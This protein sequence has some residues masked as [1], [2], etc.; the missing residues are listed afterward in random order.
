M[1]RLS[2]HSW[3]EKLS[4]LSP[5]FNM[6]EKTNLE[7]QYRFLGRSGLKVSVLSLGGN[8]WSLLG[9]GWVTMGSQIENDVAHET[10]KVAYDAG[11]NFFDNGKIPLLIMNSTHIPNPIKPKFML[12]E[13][14]SKSWEKPSKNMDGLEAASLFLQRSIGAERE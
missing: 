1:R 12:M 6:A 4:S 14:V 5:T 3:G 13:K 11:V 2:V 8:L 9:L 7:M 10:M